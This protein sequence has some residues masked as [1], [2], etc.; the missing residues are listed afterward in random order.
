MTPVVAF[1]ED[2]FEAQPNPAEVSEVF[3]VPLDFFR[4]EADH[5][6]YPVPSLPVPLHSFLYTDPTSGKQQHIW[7]LTATLAILVA[8]LAS[9]KKPEFDV[10]YDLDNPLPFFKRN[11][12]LW[13]SKLWP[14]CLGLF[15]LCK[16]SFFVCTVFVNK[17]VMT[18]TY[19]CIVADLWIWWFCDA[20]QKL[21]NKL[22]W[23]VPNSASRGQ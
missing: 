1:I 14:L 9:Q 15:V 23:P 13:I 5:S 10:G 6:L 17:I 7:G 20:L 3:T 21:S 19:Y 22:T 16:T 4:K 11:I 2:S 18:F 8:I 12:D